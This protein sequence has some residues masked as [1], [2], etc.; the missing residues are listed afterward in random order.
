MKLCISTEFP[1]I[2]FPVRGILNFKTRVVDK[3]NIL[4][5]AAIHWS[6]KIE[7]SSPGSWEIH[8]LQEGFQ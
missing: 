8:N 1:Q 2:C 4:N 3:T 6:I 7:S 5:F